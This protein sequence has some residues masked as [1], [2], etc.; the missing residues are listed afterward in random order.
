LR[1]ESFVNLMSKNSISGS[2]RN[3]LKPADSG[4]FVWAG[5]AHALH[6]TIAEVFQ[7]VPAPVVQDQFLQA[8]KAARLH[9]NNSFLNQN[10]ML[11]LQMLRVCAP[12]SYNRDGAT[13]TV[14]SEL[15][16]LN[17]YGDQESMPRHQ[18]RQPM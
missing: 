13:T 18:F 15:V 16:F 1:L 14:I 2:V 3:G 17:P 12:F 6:V 4:I 9:R 5:E 8:R 10:I 7:E 11:N